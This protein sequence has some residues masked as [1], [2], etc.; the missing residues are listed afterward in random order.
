MKIKNTVVSMSI[1]ATTGLIS[2]GNLFAA[3]GHGSADST[4]ATAARPDVRKGP[5]YFYCKGDTVFIENCEDRATEPGAGCSKTFKSEQEKKDLQRA[6][7]KSDFTKELLSQLTLDRIDEFKPLKPEDVKNV[8]Q[9][10]DTHKVEHEKLRIEMTLE[11]AKEAIDFMEAMEINTESDDQFQKYKLAMQQLKDLVKKAEAKKVD[12]AAVNASVEAANRA[13]NGVVDLVCNS[14]VTQNLNDDDK[15]TLLHTVL[16]QYDPKPVA[17]KRTLANGM[18]ELVKREVGADSKNRDF[19]KDTTIGLTWGPIEDFKK[20]EALQQ[21]MNLTIKDTTGFKN[22]DYGRAAEEYC[23]T[24]GMELPS[25]NDFL[26]ALRNPESEKG[27][28]KGWGYGQNIALKGNLP[29]MKDRCFWSSSPR[30]RTA[31]SALIFSGDTGMVGNYYRSYSGCST[32]CV[33]R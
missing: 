17:K 14:K 19:W 21:K 33:S 16:K 20:V 9:K 12:I 3:K 27:I 2:A 18:L 24:L 8:A 25:H 5:M 4:A 13:L 22:P 1:A 29:D 6:V 11:E 10:G 7:K 23:K 15:G 26:D 32:R 28:N 30:P 31:V